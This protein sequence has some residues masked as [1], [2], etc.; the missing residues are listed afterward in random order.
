MANCWKNLGF[1]H[2]VCVLFSSQ[3]CSKRSY[4][5]DLI[6]FFFSKYVIKCIP[7]YFILI[8]ISYSTLMID[9]EDYWAYTD[10]L[11]FFIYEIEVI[12][13][14]SK[15]IHLLLDSYEVVYNLH[16]CLYVFPNIG[17]TNLCLYPRK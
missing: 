14:K 8:L 6:I 16:R 1:S 5:V 11:R 4:F 13:G 10:K 17:V 12:S 15:L 7:I 3:L 2:E 9:N